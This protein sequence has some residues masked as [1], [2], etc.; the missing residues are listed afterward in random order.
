MTQVHATHSERHAC[1]STLPWLQY[2]PPTTSDIY[3]RAHYHDSSTC[4][5]RWVTCTQE[6]TTMTPIY[7]TQ[8]EWHIRKSTLPWLWYMPPTASD[9]YA[10]AHFHDSSICHPRR[11]TCAHKHI[12][13]SSLH[14]THSEWHTCKSIPPCL[15]CMAPMMS[16]MHARAWRL[17]P[18]MENSLV[19]TPKGLQ[20]PS[21]PLVSPTNSHHHVSSMCHF[22]R[23][24]YARAHHYV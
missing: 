10:R 5:P 19:D 3:A 12:T 23:G 9:M 18:R 22:V 24:T 16:G 15:Q 4:H 2:M 14:A 20:N 13:M 21:P 17:K 1:K 7:A 8:G 11:V 6:N